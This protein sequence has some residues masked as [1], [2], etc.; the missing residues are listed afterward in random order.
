MFSG[1]LTD[2]FFSQPRPL[3]KPQEGD[4]GHY[5]HLSEPL[6]EHFGRALTSYHQTSRRGMFFCPDPMRMH[7]TRPCAEC[8]IG[9]EASCDSGTGELLGQREARDWEHPC[10]ISEAAFSG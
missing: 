6:N 5:F 8:G 9:S 7:M 3:P 1:Y 2:L 4:S 10:A